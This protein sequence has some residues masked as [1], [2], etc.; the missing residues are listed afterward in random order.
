[1][2]AGAGHTALRPPAGAVAPAGGGIGPGAGRSL[3]R[4]AALRRAGARVLSGARVLTHTGAG[5][6]RVLDAH[7]LALAPGFVEMHG[8]SDPAL[9]WDPAQAKTARGVPSRAVAHSSAP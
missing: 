3:G 5:R 9:L 8:H 7:G 6:A 4:V 2:A 1:M